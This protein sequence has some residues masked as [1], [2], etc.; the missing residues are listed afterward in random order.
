MSMPQI[1]EHDL[2]HL[3]SPIP[4]LSRKNSAMYR[5]VNLLKADR[6]HANAA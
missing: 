4:I 3:F 2:W 1:Y 5:H 6:G